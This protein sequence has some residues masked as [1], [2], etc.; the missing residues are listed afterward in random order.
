[1]KKTCRRRHWREK[2]CSRAAIRSNYT[3]SHSLC[4]THTCPRWRAHPTH[5]HTACLTLTPLSL[6][7]PLSG[8]RGFILSLI[9]SKWHENCSK[10]LINSAPISGLA[11]G[12]YNSTYSVFGTRLIRQIQIRFFVWVFSL[13]AYELKF[14]LLYFLYYLL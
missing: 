9:T 10:N 1:M 3:H 12:T 2:P 13:S 4:C 6:S 14:F 11:R 7:C 8:D 5:P